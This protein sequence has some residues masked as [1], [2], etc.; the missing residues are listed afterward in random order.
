MAKIE[1]TDAYIKS[2]KVGCRT[3][4]TDAKETGLLLR[5]YPSGKRVFAFRLRDPNSK[6]QNV[7]IGQYPDLKLGSARTKAADLRKR[8]REGEDVTSAA[9]EL[10]KLAATQAHAAIPTLGEIVSEYQTARSPMRKI[11]QKTKT[12]KPSEAEHRINAVFK[13]QL[14]VCVTSLT[15]DGMAAAMTAYTPMSGKAKANGQVSKAR[16]YL[17]PVLDWCAH[18]QNFAKAGLRRAVKLDVL[19]L[20][21]TI[22][23]ATDDYDITGIRDRALDHLEIGQILPL[24]RWPA[25]Q[26]PKMQTPLELDIRP[27]A[28]RFL[29]LTCA[30]KSELVVMRWEDFLQP[31]R[32]WHKPYVK[33]ISGPPRMQNLPLSDAAMTLLQSLPGYAL[34]K[35]KDLVFPNMSGGELDN[36]QRITQ[37]VQ[38]ESGTADWHRHDL[39]RTGSTIM[40]TLGVAQSVIDKIL[41]HNAPSEN[42]SV[43]QSL[44]NYLASKHLLKHVEDPQRVA[45][46]KLAEALTF[47]EAEAQLQR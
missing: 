2:L 43:S 45:L 44:K 8:V 29:L 5:A 42:D 31:L 1:L 39:R 30:R 36:W 14:P 10:I 12:G 7:V 15:V 46:N 35:D 6:I 21:Q 33:T 3:E 19:D 28:L 22:D 34:R 37:A 20:R 13:E 25:P 11:W 9:Q 18:R 47:I 17:L 4:V 26:C 24:L 40:E 32:I 41:A 38:R 27:L 16:A 23:P